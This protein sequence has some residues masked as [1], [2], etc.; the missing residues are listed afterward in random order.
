MVRT[1]PMSD[2]YIDQPD[3]M[4]WL[5]IPGGVIMKLNPPKFDKY[6]MGGISYETCTYKIGMAGPKFDGKIEDVYCYVVYRRM[7]MNVY[8]YI[9]VHLL[10]VTKCPEIGCW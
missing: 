3:W 10:S 2:A 5:N 8:I 7:Y 4:K 1:H 9:Y 6:W